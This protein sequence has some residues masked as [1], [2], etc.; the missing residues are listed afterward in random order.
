LTAVGIGLLA[1]LAYPLAASALPESPAGAD[2][3]AGPQI[4][5]EIETGKALA[6]YWDAQPVE[7]RITAGGGRVL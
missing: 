2:T 7:Y 1:G 4:V 3:G 5:R 6:D